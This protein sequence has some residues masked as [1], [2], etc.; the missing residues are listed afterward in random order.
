M[1]IGQAESTSRRPRC[2]LPSWQS[3]CAP[4]AISAGIFARDQTAV[5]HQL[6]WDLEARQRAEVSHHGHCS[7]LHY[8]AQRV[9][10]F[11]DRTRLW[12]RVTS[13]IKRSLKMKS[14]L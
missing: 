11:D 5:A 2:I 9:E 8:T 6:A 13:V 10:G 4:N 1:L 12:R 14:L 7:E 3:S